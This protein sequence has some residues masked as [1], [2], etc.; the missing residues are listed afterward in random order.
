MENEYIAAARSGQNSFWR[1]LLTVLLVIFLV[2]AGGVCL[3]IPAVVVSGGSPDLPAYLPGPLF[4]ALNLAPFAFIP[5][6]LFIGV[7]LLHRRPFLSLINPR[8]R[9]DWGR[10]WLGAGLWLALNV[11]YN[12]VF[13]A[14]KP[15]YY[16][17]SFNPLA[18]LPFLLVSLL[19][20]PVQAGAEELLFRGYLTQGFGLLRWW[21]GWL[22]PSAAFGLLHMAN[23]EVGSFGLGLTLPV[24]VGMGL[25]LGWV[26]LR[27]GSLE[28]ALGVH[29]LNNLYASLVTTF[30]SSALQTEAMFTIR[31]YDPLAELAGF[32]V[33]AV[34]FAAALEWLL[35]RRAP[36]PRLPAAP[37]LALLAGGLALS[38]AA[39]AAPPPGAAADRLPLSDCTLSAAGMRSG[40]E[41]RCGT[42]TV[43]E[44]RADPQGRQI[45][46]RVVVVKAVSRN[47]EPD[48]LFLLAG[49]PGEA[50]SE[51]FAPF[52]GLLER[53]RFKRDLVLVDQRGTGQSGPL[54]CLPPAEDETPTGPRPVLS[55]TPIG[56][57]RPLE[58]QLAEIEA[59]LRDLGEA[60]RSQYTTE[61]AMQDLDDV[62]AAL[63]YEQVNLLGVSY[64][65]R[66][67]LTY[68]RLFPERVRSLVLDGVVPP[69]W[70]LGSTM[71]ADAQRALDLVFERCL[72]DEACART[73]P[74][75]ENDFYDLLARLQERPLEVEVAHPTTGKRVTV[76]L[77]AQNLTA[78]VRLMSYSDVQSAL[79][80]L[81]IRGA[82]Q[83]DYTLLASQ[84]LLML[85][86]L[87]ESMSFGM[88]YSVYCAEDLPNLPP[89]GE[90]GA[91]YFNA[92]MTLVRAI[93]DLWAAPSAAHTSAAPAIFGGAAQGAAQTPAPTGEPTAGAE[94]TAYPAPQDEA[95]PTGQATAY[96]APGGEATTYPAPAETGAPAPTPGAGE[97]PPGAGEIDVERSFPRTDIPVLL[98][99][100]ELDPVTPPE[101]GDAVAAIFP[102]SLHLVLPGMAHANF[103]AGCVPSIIRDF[104][105]SADPAGLSTDCAQAVRPMPFFLSPVGP[106]P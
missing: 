40:V 34:V 86:S 33:L 2:L 73:Y 61:V 54:D 62:R 100:G 27:T 1:Y 41:A 96:P 81:M 82:Y 65:T 19:L 106:P 18:F 50:A 92:D 15:G 46:L 95:G 14:L 97:A 93:C 26:T 78:T 83:G 39:C 17:W 51:S 77:T 48:P 67:A 98:I 32:A 13:A 21:L 64:G 60:D 58:D 47:P 72:L 37:L 23:P 20:I 43:P 63:G 28:V 89:E 102:N 104:L 44:N 70:A 8:L 11:A 29:I 12:L 90:L 52:V 5:L 76:A 101:N 25:L 71:R 87:S 91:Y 30:P 22:V 45:D 53:V 103:Y 75:F 88:Y 3:T 69:G 4:L 85:G 56:A 7:R 10:F 36:A 105:E 55:P 68:T 94:A 42:L 74:D 35:R 80:P 49:G 38:L 66:A 59:C 57:E 24:Y 84:Y 99:S 6:A 16:T 79:M 9:F 31:Q